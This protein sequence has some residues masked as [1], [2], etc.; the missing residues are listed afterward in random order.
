MKADVPAGL[1]SLVAVLKQFGKL[2]T[3][4]SMPHISYYTDA[5]ELLRV[6]VSLLIQVSKIDFGQDATSVFKNDAKHAMLFQVCSF[7]A[8]FKSISDKMGEYVEENEH[9]SED[10]YGMFSHCLCS[11]IIQPLRPLME[12][13]ALKDAVRR[14]CAQF[15]LSLQSL[16]PK[17]AKT[18]GQFFAGG[19]NDWKKDL[20][21][22]PDLDDV[23]AKADV[24]LGSITGKHLKAGVDRSA[25]VTCFSLVGVAS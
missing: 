16:I 15:A 7:L 12:P 24:T 20:G 9:G 22:D 19:P 13:E 2:A 14:Q 4:L 21:E 17:L 1:T 11:D 6:S 3:A 25:Q 18:S 5:V 8:S 10:P 23:L